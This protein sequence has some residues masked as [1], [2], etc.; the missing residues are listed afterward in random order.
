MQAR[1][2]KKTEGRATAISLKRNY[3]GGGGLIIKHKAMLASITAKN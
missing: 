3:L 1:A 2:T